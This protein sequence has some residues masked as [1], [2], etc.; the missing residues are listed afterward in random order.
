[1]AEVALK[2][3][4]AS[5]RGAQVLIFDDA[6]SEPIEVDFRGSAD[7]V[8]RRT[9]PTEASRSHGGSAA[10]P[11]RPKLGVVA[12]GHAPAATLGLAQRSARRHLGRAAQAR[13]WSPPRQRKQGSRAALAGGGLPVHVRH[14]RRPSRL[15]GGA[16][17]LFAGQRER[18]DQLVEAW[19][20]DI[21][22]HARQ[23]AALALEGFGA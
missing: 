12:R 23:L 21:R 5:D 7:E 17:A 15:R 20:K 1:L 3:K 9:C 4:S 11:G 6:T 13:R 19:P 10:R 16:R 14:G 18:F 8:L 2:A 22:A